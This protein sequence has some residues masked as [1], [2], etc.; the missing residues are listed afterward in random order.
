MSGSIAQNEKAKRTIV[1]ILWLVAIVL[2]AMEGYRANLLW[3]HNP[4]VEQS[5]HK[6]ASDDVDD[7]VILKAIGEH[8]SITGPLFWWHNGWLGKVY[9][10]YW[11]PLTMCVFWTEYQLFGAFRFDRWQAAEVFFHFLFAGVLAWFGYGLTRS[12]FVPPLTVIV[13]S[14][15]SGVVLPQISTYVLSLTTPASSV[16]LSNWK[17]QPEVWTGI[18]A[19]LS[20][21]AA[22]RRRWA[23]SLALA[24]A[25]VCVKETGW[26]TFAMLLATLLYTGDLRK[27][28]LAAW[29]STV[30]VC[31]ALIALRASAGH[32]VLFPHHD[33]GFATGF[34]RYLIHVVDP[35]VLQ[36]TTDSWPI[37]VLGA[38]LVLLAVKIRLSSRRPGSSP[39]PMWTTRFFSKT[40]THTGRSRDRSSGGTTAGM[41]RRTR[42]TGARLRC[43][44]SG[45]NTTYSAHTAS[46]DGRWRTCSSTSCLPGCLHGSAIDLPALALSLLSHSSFL[47]V[48]MD[49]RCRRSRISWCR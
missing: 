14:G 3:I 17:D 23:L 4:H 5:A 24:A 47:P 40:S 11:R 12:R 19:L 16:V 8:R 13:F 29:V 41:V 45:A 15:F 48:S 33:A 25:A 43:S 31:G 9:P 32:N 35:N 21:T 2:L 34:A 7:A 46:T 22:M 39:K 38:F 49:S 27:I 1:I 18:F 10:R 44:V 26:L 6:F 37:A 20:M 28:P 42:G 36:I 30:V